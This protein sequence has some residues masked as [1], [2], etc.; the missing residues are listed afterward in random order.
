VGPCSRVS[1]H[2]RKKIIPQDAL[3]NAELIKIFRLLELDIGIIVACMP[4]AARACRHDSPFYEM[5]RSRWSISRLFG[6]IGSKFQRNTQDSSKPSAGEH[7][8]SDGARN[9]QRLPYKQ[10][11][12]NLD[13]FPGH[14]NPPAAKTMR[15]FIHGKKQ[16]EV[17]GDGIH[18]TYEMQQSSYRPVVSIGRDVNS[19]VNDWYATEQK[20][21]LRT[22]S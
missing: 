19:E 21:N 14:L 20:G 1:C 7:Q 2:V 10:L 15:T 11:E 18:L 12:D 16:D 4:A 22:P 3:K 17:D 13:R 9:P 6:T 5:L 8:T